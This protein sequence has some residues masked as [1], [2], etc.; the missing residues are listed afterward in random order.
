MPID[1]LESRIK[2]LSSWYTLLSDDMELCS[3]KKEAVKKKLAKRRIRDMEDKRLSISR[4]KTINL[5]LHA[6]ENSDI[7][8]QGK[9][10]R[11]Q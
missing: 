3:P 11:L 4:K 9:Y 5:R 6:A 7:N 2:Y 1:V 10:T 8:L